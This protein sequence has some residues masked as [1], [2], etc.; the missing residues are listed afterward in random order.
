MV[1]QGAPLAP[2]V[3]GWQ[4]SLTNGYETPFSLLNTIAA[5]RGT[6]ALKLGRPR[7]KHSI[8]SYSRRSNITTT[9]TTF[10]HRCSTVLDTHGIA[11]LCSG[12]LCSFGQ[13]HA[14]CFLS[15]SSNARGPARAWTSRTVLY[16]IHHI[17]HHNHP[18]RQGN[19]G[20]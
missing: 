14:A 12:T 13:M 8:K 6:Q 5:M 10:P 18:C 4:G 20:H 9:M 15:V 1:G 3:C 11:D 2:G 7:R 16:Y 19:F 17:H